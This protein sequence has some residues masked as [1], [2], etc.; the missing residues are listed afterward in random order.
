MTNVSN[1]GSQIN[2][3]FLLQVLRTR[4]NDTQRIISTG[5]KSDTLAGMGS[6]GAS[7]SIAFRSKVSTLEGY[8]S[9]LN[10]AKPKLTIM[11]KAMQYIADDARATL[12]LLR[13]QLQGS[14]PQGTILSGDATSKLQQVISQLSVEVNGQ[15]QFAGDDLYNAPISATTALDTNVGG[16]V[17]GFLAGSPTTSSVVTAAR[18]VSGTNLGYSSTLLASGNVSFRADDNLDVDYTV[19]A[20]QQGFSDVLRGLA[21]IK[22]LPQPTTPTE[23]T[24]YWTVVNGAMQLLDEGSRAIDLYQGN[25]GTKAKL[26]DELVSQHSAATADYEIFIGEVE[27]ADVAEAAT[28]LQAI[29][30]Q[31]QASYSIIAQLKDLSLVNY[32]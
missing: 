15:Y 23:Q 1:L 25:L 5:K 9:N 17:A 19:K 14:T 21:L 11:D 24:N 20:S 8:T 31:L 16:L 32:I 22:N 7:N 4:L 6:R 13:S 29:Q 18:A 10:T 2:N 28:R 27:D 26:V 3:E 30:S 12:N